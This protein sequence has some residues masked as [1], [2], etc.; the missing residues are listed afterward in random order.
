M[1]DDAAGL[2]I[3][4][5]MPLPAVYLFLRSMHVRFSAT[6]LG[7]SQMG[8]V[9]ELRVTCGRE[10]QMLRTILGS[11]DDPGGLYRVTIIVSMSRRDRMQRGSDAIARLVKRTRRNA[12]P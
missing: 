2:E 4:R 5:L 6:C 11:E 7:D 9:L 12:P 1:I 3:L 10:G 8:I